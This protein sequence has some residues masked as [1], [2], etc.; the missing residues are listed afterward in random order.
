MNLQFVILNL[1]P[2]ISP[3]DREFTHRLPDITPETQVWRVQIILVH[4]GIVTPLNYRIG[5]SS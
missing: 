4:V 2:V 3:V 5:S 1:A